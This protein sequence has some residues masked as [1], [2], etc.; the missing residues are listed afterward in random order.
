[1]WPSTTDG[2]PAFGQARE[3]RARVLREVAEVLGHLGRTGR[4]VEPDDVGPHR[5]ERGERG[6]DL[7]ADEH[8]AG[9]LDR[10]LHH[11]AGPR[12]PTAAIARRHAI[13]RG[14][15]P[16][17]GRRRSRRA[18]R[19]RRPRAAPPPAPGSRRAASANVM[20]AERRE[21]GAGTDRADHEPGPVGRANSRRPTSRAIRAA[22]HVHLVGPVRRCRTR[23]ARARRRRRWRSRPRRRRPRSTRR[24]SGAMRSGRVSTRC[25]LQP[26]SAGPP[27]SSAVEV[28]VLDP[29]AEGA[30]ED[31]DPLARARRGSRPS[32]HSRYRSG[33]APPDD[34]IAPDSPSDPPRHRLAPSMKVYTRTGD[35]GTTGAPLRRTGRQGR[36]RA[37]RPTARSTR[38]SRRS[39]SPGPRSSGAPSSTTCSSGSS[40][41]SSWSVPSSRPRPPTGRSSARRV[42]S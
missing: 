14:L 35:D 19:R 21:P 23:R 40:V 10:D 41:S 4:A 5:L 22:G 3:E 18:A 36:D 29:G 13:E 38:P 37:R 28:L 16:G 32:N 7:G 8:A 33:R 20:C 39:G 30:V 2:S 25:S 24:A 1:M 42:A 31:E 27:K 12:G 6:A 17:A 11:A 26:S 34:S 15:A 9:R